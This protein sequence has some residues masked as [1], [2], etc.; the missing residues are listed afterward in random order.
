MNHRDRIVE[1]KSKHPFNRIAVLRYVLIV[2]GAI[3]VV[4]L[5]YV[6]I[7]QHDYYSAQ[8]MS[9]H[10]KKFS[11]PAERGTISF[12]EGSDGVLPVVLNEERYLVYADPQFIKDP[13][14]TAHRLVG[15]LGGDVG[16]LEAKL[17]TTGS[18]YVILAKK[19]PKDQVAR[20][21]ELELLGIGQ[22]RVSVRT[23]PQGLIAAQVL[24]FVNDDGQGQYGIEGY[25][26]DQLSG[27]AGQQKA[28]TD[29]RGVP[30]ANNDNILKTAKNGTDL[31][32]TLGR[33]RFL[34]F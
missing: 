33:C 12:Q 13:T 4:R 28:I 8:A 2:L 18:R 1:T 19:L 27:V 15:V 10:V 20:I 22:K 16:Q 5:F 26:N 30:L 17:K 25:L 34:P 24:G 32:L 21:Q 11:I 23:Y 9:E 29:V 31:E 3:L 14:E 6:Q 7:V